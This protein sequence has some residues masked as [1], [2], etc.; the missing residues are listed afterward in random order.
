[1]R[2]RSRSEGTPSSASRSLIGLELLARN[3][4]A[5]LIERAI[6]SD[7]ALDHVGLP[8]RTPA[9]PRRC[10]GRVELQ[11]RGFVPPALVGLEIDAELRDLRLDRVDQV[12]DADPPFRYGTEVPGFRSRFVTIEKAS[13]DLEIA[14][15]NVEHV[16]PRPRR[17]RVADDRGLTA[18]SGAHHVR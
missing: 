17:F 5:A 13:A 6:P 18:E 9:E 16:L 7:R 3:D 14:G 8:P 12:P 11:Q 4:P 15:D 2:R 1:M 10:L